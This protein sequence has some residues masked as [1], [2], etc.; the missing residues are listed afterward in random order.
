MGQYSYS[1]PSSS[2]DNDIYLT[3]L[4]QEEAD[5]YADEAESSQNI[6][7]PVQYPSQE[8]ADIYADE[9]D[10]GIPKSCYCGA[11]PVVATAYTSKDPGRRFS[12]RSCEGSHGRKCFAV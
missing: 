8:E 2:E 1:Q 6:V 3:W 11:E 5:I 7:E 12:T 9:A 10:D 4:L